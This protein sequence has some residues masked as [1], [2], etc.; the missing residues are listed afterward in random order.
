MK[1]ADIE[2]DSSV[3]LIL[4]IIGLVLLLILTV[5]LLLNLE[6]IGQTLDSIIGDV[7]WKKPFK[8]AWKK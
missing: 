4:I 7:F 2:L 5:S 3:E 1:K 8:W 6:T